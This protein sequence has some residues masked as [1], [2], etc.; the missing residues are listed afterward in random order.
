MAADYGATDG[1]KR[2]VMLEHKTKKQ[3]IAKLIVARDE[4]EA[5]LNL[6]VPAARLRSCPRSASSQ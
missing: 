3:V 5:A 4:I 1:G 2:G 6:S